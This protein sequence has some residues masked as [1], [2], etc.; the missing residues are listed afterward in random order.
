MAESWS[1]TEILAVDGRVAM[2][3]GVWAE[4]FLLHAVKSVI[5]RQPAEHG[6]VSGVDRLAEQK[7]VKCTK[8]VYDN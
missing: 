4:L 3:N 6:Q 1:M 8:T 5:D 7:R 2:E